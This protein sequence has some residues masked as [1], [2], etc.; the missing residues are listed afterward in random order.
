MNISAKGIVFLL[1]VVLLVQ[2]RGDAPNANAPKGAATNTGKDSSKTPEKV[3]ISDTV[4]KGVKEI[5][6]KP[7]NATEA[8]FTACVMLM[9]LKT[10][11]D[12]KKIKEVIGK[13]KTQK[14]SR[15]EKITG[16]ILDKCVKTIKENAI[17]DVIKN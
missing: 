17:N 10:N 7:L 1:F 8:R 12:E 16:M 3:V 5:D 6:D 2:V 14:E 15:Y 9:Y 11:T 13:N 4:K